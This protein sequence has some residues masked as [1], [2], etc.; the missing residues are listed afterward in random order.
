[1]TDTRIGWRSKASI[2]GHNGEVEFIGGISQDITS[3]KQL[4]RDLQES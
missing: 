4:E 1:M 3:H 2:S